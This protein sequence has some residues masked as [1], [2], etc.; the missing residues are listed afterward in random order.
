MQASGATVWLTGLPGSGKST[1]AHALSEALLGD[2]RRVEVLDGDE[3][4][5]NLSSDL[6]FSAHDRN[7]HVRR[8]GFVAQLLAG[9]GV[10]AV[11]PVIA[12]YAAARDAVRDQH[13]VRGCDYFEV[14]VATP[15]TECMRRDPKG[16]YKRAEAGELS[17]LTGYD[18]AYEAPR[19]PDLRLDTT[20]IDI[21]AAR[22][23]VLELLDRRDSAARDVLEG[24]GTP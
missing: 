7:V 1:L 6:G 24:S 8:V 12:P 2:G 5:T 21:A 19:E 22:D 18:A 17:G 16:L 14:H 23:A 4:R 3:L 20:D 9:Q 13:A 11:V 15:A 10:V